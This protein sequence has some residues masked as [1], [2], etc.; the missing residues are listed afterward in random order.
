MAIICNHSKADTE[1]WAL[2]KGAYVVPTQL[3]YHPF[4]CRAR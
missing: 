4:P 2:Q 3:S 1:R